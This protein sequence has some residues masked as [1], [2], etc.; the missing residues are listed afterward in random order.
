[1]LW[2]MLS[3]APGGEASKLAY[4]HKRLRQSLDRKL[5]FAGVEFV[6]VETREGH[7]VLHVIWAWRGPRSFYVPQSWLS[8]EWQRIHGARVVW[9][10]RLRPGDQSRKSVARYVVTQYC[11]NQKALVRLSWSWWGLTVALA[12]GWESLKRLASE[13]YRDDERKRWVRNYVRPM[14]EVVA[15]W[16]SLLTSG[17]ALLGETWLE[18]RGR[19]VVEVF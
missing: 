4:H 18:V 14:A 7:G 15:A 16:Q 9:V 17:G 13:T 2:V 11:A 19:D 1:M 8:A 12:S 6:Q 3:T 10:E 5:G